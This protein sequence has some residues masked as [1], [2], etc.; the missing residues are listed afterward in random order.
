M[1]KEPSAS[2][3]W[4][5]SPAAQTAVLVE[6]VQRDHEQEARYEYPKEPVPEDPQV[7]ECE[8]GDEHERE[9]AD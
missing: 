7:L 1:A 8:T 2:R 6:Q 9:H 3:R 5:G 4:P